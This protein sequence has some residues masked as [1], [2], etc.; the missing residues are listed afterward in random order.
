MKI[1]TQIIAD[2]EEEAENISH[3]VV[4]LHIH[5]RD[6]QISYYKILREKT[7]VVPFA[8]KNKDGTRK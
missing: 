7:G 8:D 4:T 5:V 6:F 3:G 2:V 1:P